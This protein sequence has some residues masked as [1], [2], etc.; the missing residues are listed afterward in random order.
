MQSSRY[1][2]F[3]RVSLLVTACVLVFDSGIIS[4]I[5]KQL[6]NTT[7][8]YL[9]SV[10]SSVL[11]SVP[12]NELNTLSAQIAEEQRSLAA[13]EAALQEREIA[14]RSFGGSEESEYSTYLIS[15]MLFIIIVLLTLNYVL[16]FA[17]M[18]Q[19]K[20]EKQTT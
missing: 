14:A 8:V 17:R 13:R 12:E 9:G 19:F 16:D 7:F 2:S 6:S 3:L 11:A 5:S 1:H 18:R 20:Y 10:G 4:P 15:V